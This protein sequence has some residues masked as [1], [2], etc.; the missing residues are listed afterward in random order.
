M[1]SQFHKHP[2][3]SYRGTYNGRLFGPIY[4][5]TLLN[6]NGEYRPPNYTAGPSNQAETHGTHVQ[7]EQYNHRGQSSGTRSAFNVNK[8]F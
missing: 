3:T 4:N 2:Q 6:L 8:R 1:N 5:G 7:P